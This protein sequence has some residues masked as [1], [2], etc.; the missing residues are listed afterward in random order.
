[1][2][3]PATVVIA[4]LLSL[5]SGAA[6][7]VPNNDVAVGQTPSFIADVFSRFD[8]AFTSRAQASAAA[9]MGYAM[10]FLALSFTVVLVWRTLQWFLEGKHLASLIGTLLN[11]MLHYSIVLVF[12]VPVGSSTGYQGTVGMVSSMADTVA[13]AAS[14]GVF[15]SGSAAILTG[16]GALLKSGF[17]SLNTLN[18]I[19][20]ARTV[21]QTG[22][23]DS[24]TSG[25]LFTGMLESIAFVL[26]AFAILIAT[27]YAGFQLAKVVLYG[28][29]AFALGAAVGPF[30]LGFLLLP[31]TR[32]LGEHWFKFMLNAA[33]IKVVAF[34]MVGVIVSMGS[35]LIPPVTN[36]AALQNLGAFAILSSYLALILVYV[37]VGWVLGQSITLAGSLFGASIGGFA[38]GAGLASLA[39][40]AAGVAAGAAAVLAKKA[41]AG[42][43]AVKSGTAAASDAASGAAGAPSGSTATS[44]SLGAPASAQASAS[45][46]APASGAASAVAGAAS[47]VASSSAGSGAGKAFAAGAAKVMGAAAVGTANVMAGAA[48][49]AG[50][51]AGGTKTGNAMGKAFSDGA[52]VFGSGPSASKSPASNK[53]SASNAFIPPPNTPAK[54]AYINT[55]VAEAE[56]LH[57]GKSQVD[58]DKAVLQA[59]LNAGK[60]FDAREAAVASAPPAS[61]DNSSTSNAEPRAANMSTG[62]AGGASGSNTSPFGSQGGGSSFASGSSAGSNAQT[63]EQA[64]AAAVARHREATGAGDNDGSTRAAGKAAFDQY[65]AESSKGQVGSQGNASSFGGAQSGSEKTISRRAQNQINAAN[66]RANAVG[67]A[68]DRHK[69][70]TGAT[71]SDE[72]TRSA[73]KAALAQ[74]NASI[75]K[76]AYVNRSVEKAVAATGNQGQEKRD[77]AATVSAANASKKFDSH[78]PQTIERYNRAVEAKKVKK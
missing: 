35:S 28:V 33:F 24:L 39:A 7:A 62:G 22:L 18:A 19:A 44:G 31:L 55:A 29:V 64:V 8:S 5:L 75:G 42:M 10:R 48:K 49:A 74:H 12:L 47:S 14:G 23:W 32:A 36:V 60:S 25:S 30:F 26:A 21:T 1:M 43:A 41:S 11:M 53:S 40:G 16:V 77:Q 45:G 38:P 63:R 50:A 15:T 56:S 72:S 67:V 66:A 20:Q 58:R 37:M 57:A 76:T 61:R 52:R 59:S 51:I 34:F 6:F 46:S 13:T 73:G 17:E 71:D 54:Q 70:A 65:N 3:I 2:R 27:A 4:L 78:S 69:A 9:L 68:I